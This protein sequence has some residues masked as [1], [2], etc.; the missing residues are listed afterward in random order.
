MILTKLVDY[1]RE[2]EYGRKCDRCLE[3]TIEGKWLFDPPAGEKWWGKLRGTTTIESL[4]HYHNE[5][6]SG[7]IEWKKSVDLCP[8]CFKLL[9]AWLEAEGV[10]MKESK[11]YF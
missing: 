3:E 1:K 5:E 6:S 7:G 10:K 11:E 9:E 4:Y 2:E 8:G